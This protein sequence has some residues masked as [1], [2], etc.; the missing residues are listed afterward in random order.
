LG[1]L[2][3]C[4]GLAVERELTKQN[5]LSREKPMGNIKIL[6]G[7]DQQTHLFFGKVSRILLFNFRVWCMQEIKKAG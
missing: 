2:A 7:F 1:L 4:L 3:R 6:S 5:V